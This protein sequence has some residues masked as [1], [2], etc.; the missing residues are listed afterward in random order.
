MENKTREEKLEIV[1]NWL[2][3]HINELMIDELRICPDDDSPLWSELEEQILE[4]AE[5]AQIK[6]IEI[7][8]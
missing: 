5:K 8:L 1:S 4:T 6:R 2:N 7:H 3:R